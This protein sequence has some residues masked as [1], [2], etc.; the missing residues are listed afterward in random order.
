MNT[1][2]LESSPILPVIA[3][4]DAANALP[5]AEAL[6]AGG[7]S[8]I[9]VTFRTDAAVESISTIREKLPEMIVSAGTV[10]TL[11]QAQKAIDA[12]AQFGLAPGLDA[13]V[14]ALFNKAG[15]SFIPGVMT[16]SEV[17]AALKL[18]CH[19]MKFFP[20]EAAGGLPLLK[21]LIAPF[22][23]HGVKFCPTGGVKPSNMADYLSLEE[24][25]AV[26]GT[27]LATPAQINAGDW[28]SI[29]EQVKIAM[30]QL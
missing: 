2:I 21:S 20:A 10:V 25:F 8:A 15:L 18:G 16:P 27:W 22:K 12:G 29:E 11:E 4:D 24:V 19:H 1:D 30:A 3:I 7:I 9:E 5:L 28:S 17:Q 26:G 14:V 6:V 13:D 23:S